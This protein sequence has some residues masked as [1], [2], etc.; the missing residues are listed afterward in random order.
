VDVFTHPAVAP[1]CTADTIGDPELC[2]RCTKSPDCSGPTCDPAQCVLC[3]GQDQDD[4]P[5]GCD[6]MNECPDSTPCQTS[7]E[8]GDGRYC[9]SGCCVEVVIV[10]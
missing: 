1:D 4:L 3:P 8:C 7:A 6:G 5:P 9:A 10:D 2:P